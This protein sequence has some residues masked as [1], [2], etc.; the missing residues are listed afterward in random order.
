MFVCE[1]GLAIDEGVKSLLPD[2]SFS[3]ITRCFNPKSCLP[4]DTSAMGTSSGSVLHLDCEFM[5]SEGK[6][7]GAGLFF[8]VVK[9]IEESLG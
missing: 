7:G 5:L 6:E 2:N 9:V 8:I 1:K 3:A 4:S